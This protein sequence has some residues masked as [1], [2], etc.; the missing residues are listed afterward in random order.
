MKLPASCVPELVAA[1]A[2]VGLP[3]NLDYDRVGG[4]STEARE[5]LRR[6]RP[7]TLAAATRIPGVTP[8]AL[9]VVLAHVRR[10]GAEAA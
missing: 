8:A 7:G 4:L 9:L 3:S 6:V 2:A 10:M 1:E 5:A